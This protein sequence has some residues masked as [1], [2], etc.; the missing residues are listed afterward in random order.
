MEIDSKFKKIYRQIRHLFLELQTEIHI[1][2]N[3]V[4][5]EG[6]VRSLRQN[7]LTT[8]LTYLEMLI[9]DYFITCLIHSPDLEFFLIIQE[10]E[11]I[12][13]MGEDLIDLEMKFSGSDLTNY[14]A[15]VQLLGKKVMIILRKLNGL[16]LELADSL[17]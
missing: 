2:F 5:E 1:L 16:V 6:P 3:L 7:E 4:V 11:I 17:R 9:D 14:S 8:I 10:G 15:D 13:H 12:E